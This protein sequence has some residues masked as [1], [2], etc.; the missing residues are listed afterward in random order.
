MWCPIMPDYREQYGASAWNITREAIGKELRQRYESST[1]LPP[2]VLALARQ[3]TAVEDGS[4]RLTDWHLSS[5]RKRSSNM[6]R[7]MLVNHLGQA[8]R[9]IREGERLILR[10]RQLVDELERHGHGQSQTANLARDVLQSFETTQSAHI[11]D[12]G[13]LKQALTR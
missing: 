4:L 10:Q 5:P 6:N 12:K 7:A 8:E 2:P 13:R 3:L 1:E 11:V 9:H